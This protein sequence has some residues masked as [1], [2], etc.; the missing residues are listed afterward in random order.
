MF[1]SNNQ[2]NKKCIDQNNISEKKLTFT[3]PTYHEF[4]LLLNE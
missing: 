3:P 1:Y 4:L 2:R